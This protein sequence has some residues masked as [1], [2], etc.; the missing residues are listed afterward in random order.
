MKRSTLILIL[1]AVGL[2][3]FV[4]FYEIK[5]GGTRDEKTET[6]K[7]AF[8]FKRED[9][10]SLTLTRGG[11]TVALEQQDNKWVIKQPVNAAADQSTVDSLVNGLTGARIERSLQASAE[12]L[13]SYG[14]QEPAVIIELKLKNG[15]QHRLRLGAKAPV[16]VS[17]YGQVD[18]SPEVALLSD[19][20]LASS[21]KSLNDLRDR[22]VL[23]VSRYDL[24]ALK[25]AN[26]HGRIELAKKD[27][28]WAITAPDQANADENQVNSLIDDLT[29]ATASEIVSET[30]DELGK[31]GLEQPKITL[32]A[33][34]QGGGER[35]LVISDKKDDSYY[36]KNSGQP[37]VFKVD[38]SLFDKLN[39][40]FSDLRDKQ[41]IKLEKDQ[42]TRL[43]L[44][45]QNLTLLA[46][47]NPDGKWIV[48]QPEDKKDK[49]AQVDRIF[50]AIET[51]ATEVL[52]KPAPSISAKLVKPAAEVQLTGKD[53]KTTTIK[54]SA[55]DGDNAYVRVE[56]KPTIYKVEKR[57]VENLNLK[58]SDVGL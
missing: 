11:Q 6:S 2:G 37:Q 20:L 10:A 35:T 39:I 33:G 51:K 34:L 29:S 25:L 55:A 26:E 16:G 45:N 40:K 56:G 5:R 1:I 52:E 42:L 49:E 14:L 27:S 50:D 57:V 32:T 31:Y 7:P 44:K 3:A 48:K 58:A 53:G 38:A 30:A 36:A 41:I 54:V 18:Q 17:V 13:K 43:Q 47:K 24:S 22:S 46:E 4:Y 28:T 12:E 19:S 15:E 9:L 21:D 8:N 23:G